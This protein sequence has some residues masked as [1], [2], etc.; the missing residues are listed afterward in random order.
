MD[1]QTRSI[2][3][4]VLPLAIAFVSWLIVQTKKKEHPPEAPPPT[5][6]A[7]P[8]RLPGQPPPKTKDGPPAPAEADSG[9]Q[10]LMGNPSR[11]VA[12]TRDPDNYLIRKA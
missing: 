11:A 2:L 5:E 4:T 6:Q 7:P 1:K 3:A 8:P 9:I 10:L 12:E